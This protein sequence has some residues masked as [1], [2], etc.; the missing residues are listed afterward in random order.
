MFDESPMKCM[1]MKA[2]RTETGM[3]MMG[4]MADGKCHRKTRI[5][6]LTMAISSSSSCFRLSM[7]RWIR[8]ERS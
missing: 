3:V 5:T 8:S 1:G 6:R 2:S 4:T 7:E